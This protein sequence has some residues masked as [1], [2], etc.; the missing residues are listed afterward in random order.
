MV[1]SNSVIYTTMLGLLF[2]SFVSTIIAI[3]VLPT[4]Q[5]PCGNTYQP[6]L[7][8]YFYNKSELTLI[9]LESACAV[10]SILLCFLVYINN[11]KVL[12]ILVAVA[13]LIMA[14]LVMANVVQLSKDQNPA[15]AAKYDI[16][17]NISIPIKYISMALAIIACVL[18]F[19]YY[20][21][22]FVKD[23]RHFV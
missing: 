22:N 17:D 5:H 21:Q 10:V 11:F 23:I 1:E 16:S 12:S 3:Y 20:G 7:F 2:L 18:V 6:P 4:N 19:Y 9:S 14:S 13:L 15:I 8:Y